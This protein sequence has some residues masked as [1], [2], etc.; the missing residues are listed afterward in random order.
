VHRFSCI[1]VYKRPDDGSP[2]E[3]KQEAVN[4]P[5][6][7]VL[8]V[9]ALIHALCLW[10]FTQNAGNTERDVLT[11]LKLQN[12]H[13]DGTVNVVSTGKERSSE[14]R[15]AEACQVTGWS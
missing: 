6:K 4:K 13:F 14:W 9:T 7:L 10:D 2:L 1:S 5:I 15:Y 12:A 8:R 11:F 3:S